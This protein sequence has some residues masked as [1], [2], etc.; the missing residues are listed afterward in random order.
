MHGV[1]LTNGIHKIKTNQTT[2][3]Q[4]IFIL[5]IEEAATGFTHL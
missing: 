2:M 3:E 5:I 4:P 1:R